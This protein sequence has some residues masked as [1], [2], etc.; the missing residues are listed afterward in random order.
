MSTTGESAEMIED[1]EQ[2]RKKQQ[3]AR[4][5]PEACGKFRT[6]A[7]GVQKRPARGSKCYA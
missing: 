3:S 7:V 5:V 6:E 4:G 2:V 1:I